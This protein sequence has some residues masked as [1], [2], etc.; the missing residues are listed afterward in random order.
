MNG[1][2]MSESTPTRYRESYRRILIDMHIPD[3][4][5]DFLADYRPTDAVAAAADAGASGLMLYFQ[6]HTGLCYWPTRSGEQ[7][8]AFRGRD[9]IAESLEAARAHGLPVCAYYSVNFNNW[10]WERHPD[11]RLEPIASGVIGGGLLQRPRYGLCCMNHPGY[12]QFAA[13]QIDEIVTDYEVD[14]LFCDMVWWMSICGCPSCRE[15]CREETGREMPAAIDWL[16]PRWC[17]FQSARERWVIELAE[18]LRDRA[19]RGRPGLDV[20]HNFALGMTNWTRGVSFESAAAHDFLGG[21]FYGG[22]DEQLVISRLMLNLSPQRPVEFMTTV[23]ANL[24]QH[25]QLKPAEALRLQN[26]AA[27]ATGSAF[28]MITAVDP[29]GTLNPAMLERCADAFG[30]ARAYEPFLGGEPVEDIG[31]YFSS[32]SKMSFADNGKRLADAPTDSPTAYPHFE[33]V[34]GAC[35]ALQRAHLPFGVVTRQQLSALGRYKA[36]ILPNVLRMDGKE[37]RAFREYVDGGGKLYASCFTSLTDTRGNRREDFMLADVFGCRFERPETGL[38]I[39]LEPAAAGCREALA[40]ERCVSHWVGPEAQP[41]ALRLA[42]SSE[43]R[44]LMNLN[45]P[46]GYPSRGSAEGRD[47]ASI[48]SSPPWESTGR[49]VVVEHEFGRGR[50]IYSAVDLETGESA[51]HER[52]FVHLVDRLADGTWSFRADAHPNIWVTA[53]DQTD[54]SRWIVSLLNYTAELPAAGSGPIRLSLATPPG[55][56]VANVSSLPDER[57]IEFSSG[58]SG[59]SIAIDDCVELRMLSIAYE[60]TSTAP[61]ARS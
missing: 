58:A 5:T 18:D 30:Q 43:G 59:I 23:S 46:Y 33:A 3:W 8:R 6:A 56:Q 37:V 54:R 40:G 4:E 9:P 22:R 1:D 12:R 48:H 61:E 53:F 34:R 15:R 16:D 24:A 35:R 42:E 7:H 47:W 39:H 51:A 45:L 29:R 57:R 27:T 60:R 14:A 20:Y 32:A 38:M 25:E 19:K 52:L 2:G 17:E 21:D 13:A 49:P 36:L 10:A 41:G 44:A 50:C 26:L 28:M 11:W 31:V 55:R